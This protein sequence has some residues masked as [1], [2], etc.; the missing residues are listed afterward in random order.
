MSINNISFHVD[1]AGQNSSGTVFSNPPKKVVVLRWE[2]ADSLELMTALA[3]QALSE[4]S[5]IGASTLIYD[6]RRIPD[7]E[8]SDVDVATRVHCLSS[9]IVRRWG[10]LTLNLSF[11]ATPEVQEL[12]DAQSIQ[13]FVSHEFAMLAADIDAS[14]PAPEDRLLTLP[15]PQDFYAT[16]AGSVYSIPELTTTVI[17]TAGNVADLVLAKQLFLDGIA[18]T[19]RNGANS[20]IM[21]TSATP[22]ISDVERHKYAY[23]SV[24]MPLAQSGYFKQVVH[25]R[26]GAPLMPKGAPQLAP[27]VTAFGVPFYD[28]PEMDDAITLLRVLLGKPRHEVDVVNI[29]ER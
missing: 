13:P 28:V 5:K 2:A 29:L 23:D 24:V 8:N 3:D 17:R 15:A 27:L 12:I 19:S 22:P 25:V 16:Y 18:L 26:P 20:L 6:F 10:V 11:S 7:A 14:Y 21:D 1:I 4:M 9:G